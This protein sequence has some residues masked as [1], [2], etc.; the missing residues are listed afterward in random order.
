MRKPR[1]VSKTPLILMPSPTQSHQRRLRNASAPEPEVGHEV[2][3]VNF[4]GRWG[5]P[6]ALKCDGSHTI[7]LP[8]KPSSMAAAGSIARQI[9]ASPW[10]AAPTLPITARFGI[11]GDRIRKPA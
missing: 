11:L 3:L 2:E 9:S 4:E 10:T 5:E 1:R 6:P 8:I 7:R